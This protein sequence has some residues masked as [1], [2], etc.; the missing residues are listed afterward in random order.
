MSFHLALGVEYDGSRFHGWQWQTHHTTVQQV[1][2][3]ALSQIAAAP[4]RVAASGRTDA[5]VHATGQ[6]VS[7]T[8]R[9]IRPD[10]AWVRGVNS[11][12]PEGVAVRWVES[13]SA[14]FHARF[15][16]TARHYMY[17]LLEQTARPAL[18]RNYVTWSRQPLDDA[19][20]HRGALHL[21]G[22][23]DFSSFRAA[24]CQARTPFR[25]IH[26]INVRRF[27]ALVV[28]DVLANAFLQHMVRNI[29]G[30]LLEVGTGTRAPEWVGSVL[31]QRDRNAAARTAPPAGLYLVDVRYGD[32]FLPPPS[33]APLPL[34]G[35]PGLW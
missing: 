23:H 26:Q 33:V 6:V 7:F 5:G 17:V 13:V 12:L 22:E 20:M 4:I 25:C 2:E 34:L 24:G 8:T 21:S 29:A 28:V 19:A 30:V 9:A 14:D 31:A 10:D 11:V 3:Q 27:G 16:A 32:L 18:G 35:V 1:L 15:S